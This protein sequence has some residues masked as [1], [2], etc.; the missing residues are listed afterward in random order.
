MKAG[1]VPVI[2]LFVAAGSAVDASAQIDFQTIPCGALENAYGPYDYTDPAHKREYLPIVEVNHFNSDVYALRRGMTSDSGPLGD[3]DYTLRTFPNH[4]LALDAM[5]RLHLQAGVER[6]SNGRYSI[7]CW[8]DRATRFKPNDGMVRLIH[9]I[10]LLRADRLDSAE[11]EMKAAE[12]L[13]PA[14]PEV[15]YNLGL[16]HIRTRD[17]EAAREHAKRA[18]ELGH[19]LPGL[20]N[21][22]TRLGQ[23]TAA[24]Q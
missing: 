23:W 9:G 8:F 18:Y 1:F 4:H 13:L 21:Q 15:H 20:R 17:Y 10:Y 16:L 5:A 7:D 19:P 22:L 3:L 14:S 6:F 2:A 24:A 11:H 12:S